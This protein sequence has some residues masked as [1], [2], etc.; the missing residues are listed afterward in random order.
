MSSFCPDTR[1]GNVRAFSH[2]TERERREG[3]RMREIEG[4]RE[5]MFY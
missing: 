1:Y 4:L 5:G 3:E 2:E